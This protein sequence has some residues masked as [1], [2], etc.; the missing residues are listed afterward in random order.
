MWPS[1]VVDMGRHW[2]RKQNDVMVMNLWSSLARVGLVS[3]ILQ[4]MVTNEVFLFCSLFL[5]DEN[6][7]KSAHKVE[8]N[9][10]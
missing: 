6:K 1:I 10:V 8:L 9:L 7:I 3:L 4:R 5:K 2:M